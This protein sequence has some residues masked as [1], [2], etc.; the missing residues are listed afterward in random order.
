MKQKLSQKNK[1][2]FDL[3]KRNKFNLKITKEENLPNLQ[4]TNLNY[5]NKR[6]NLE[7]KILT[8]TD[9]SA[10]QEDNNQT[11][12][13]QK[14]S[15]IKNFKIVRFESSQLPEK[16]NHRDKYYNDESIYENI[17]VF[18]D[19]QFRKKDSRL[20]E[21][22]QMVIQKED[23]SNIFWKSGKKDDELQLLEKLELLKIEQ[24][25]NF[26]T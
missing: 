4:E 24:K 18:Q 9:L 1:K 2:Y 8:F 10:F 15:N 25:K 11:Q 19:L 14:G 5:T 17:S 16:D 13:N 12:N 23:Q 3:T 21:F 7:E 20:R 6:N 26:E 22:S